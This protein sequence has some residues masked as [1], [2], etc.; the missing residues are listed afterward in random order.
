MG[1]LEMGFLTWVWWG[2]GEREEEK[3][4]SEG[5]LESWVRGE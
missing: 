3:E 4:R 1:C 5:G 2:K